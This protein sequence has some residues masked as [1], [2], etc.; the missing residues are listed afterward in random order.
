MIDMAIA[1]HFVRA[2]ME[3]QFAEPS[4]RRR[5]RDVPSASA[6]TVLRLTGGAAGANPARA[7]GTTISTPDRAEHGSSASRAA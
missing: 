6:P 2:R 1:A 7:A 5:R 3:E 4:K